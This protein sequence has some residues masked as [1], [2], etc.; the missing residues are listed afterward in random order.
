[1]AYRPKLFAGIE[2]DGRSRA[3]CAEIAARLQMQDFPGRF[4]APEKLHV[5]LAFLGWTDA[6]QGGA[7]REA[8]IR[9]AAKTAPFTLRLDKLGAFPHERNP[10]VVWIG[11]RDQGARFRSAANAVR[12]AYEDL[13]FRFEKAAVAH[14]TIAR[15]KSSHVHLPLL[16]TGDIEVPVEHLTLFESVRDGRTTRYEAVLRAALTR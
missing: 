6:Q 13:G 11:A 16:E 2:L 14:V 9:A 4:E 1:M 7:L 10:H 5:T 3:R 15:V 8:L 12:E